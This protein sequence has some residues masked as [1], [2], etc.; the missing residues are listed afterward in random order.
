MV[1]AWWQESTTRDPAALGALAQQV[2]AEDEGGHRLDHGHGTGQHTGVVAAAAGPV[3]R[4]GPPA[5]SGVAAR[6]TLKPRHSVQPLQ[7]AGTL[8]AVPSATN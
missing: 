6:T 2:V 1:L 7:S 5:R 3:S 4:R 8:T